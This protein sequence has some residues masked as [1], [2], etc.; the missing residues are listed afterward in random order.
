MGKRRGTLSKGQKFITGL[1]KMET[2]PFTLTFTGNLESPT[3][4]HDF[5]LWE[6]A[7][8]P[9]GNPSR[10]RKTYKLYTERPHVVDLD[11]DIACCEATV[12]ATVPP[13]F[14]T[15][16]Q[17][18]NSP[19]FLLSSESFLNNFLSHRNSMVYTVQI[20]CKPTPVEKIC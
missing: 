12:L 4:L 10:Q 13:T 2:K 1:T 11:L 17:N 20:H 16:T 7:R 15:S 18:V 9:K 3:N 14:K 6:D 8:R 19:R 5:G